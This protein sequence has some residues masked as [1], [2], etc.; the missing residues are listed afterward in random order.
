MDIS[1]LEQEVL[2]ALGIVLM[3]GLSWG[4][5]RGL[6]YLG[7][8]ETAAQKAE[9]DD[10]AGKALQFGLSQLN[11][12]IQAK[13]WDHPEVK[14]QAIQMALTYAQAKFPDGLA[15]AGID[16]SSPVTAANDLA[17]IMNRKFSGEAAIAAA[18]PA[19]PPSPAQPTTT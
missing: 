5:K 2:K 12:A 14:S 19:T 7:I 9:L 3:A 16:L 15:K 6:D 8:Q 18:S 1:L 10:I 11:G 4:I 13:G 17:G